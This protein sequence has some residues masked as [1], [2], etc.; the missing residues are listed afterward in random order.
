MSAPTLVDVAKQAD[1]L[2]VSANMIWTLVC[3]FLVMFMQ[4]GFALVE[5][6]LTRSKNVAHTMAM[7]FL[8]YTI[9][10]LGFWAVGFAFQMGGVGAM[11]TFGGDA[12]LSSE[13]VVSIAGHEFGLFGMKGF[14]LTFATYTP[15]V[16]TMFLFQ[17]VFMDTTATIPTGAMAERWKF[18]SFV[19]FSFVISTVIYP[20]Y[21]NWVWGGGWLSTLGKS[22]GLGHGHVDFAGSSVVHMT[23]GVAALVGAKIL[24]PRIGKYNGDGSPN[25]I[26]GHNIPMAL[27][28]TFILA[29]GWFGFNP[30]S[31]L[32]GTDVR[33][34]IIAV[35]TML[36]SASGA[37]AAT[38]F[39]WN[40]YGKPDP[41]WLANGMLAGL[42]AITAPCAF[43]G[44]PAAIFIGAVAGV[45]VV[46]SAV[47]I[48][49][50]LKID[51]PVGASSV[52][53]ACGAWGILSLGLFAN[54]TY[55]EGLNGVEGPVR[56]LLAG[57]AG[58]FLAECVGILVNVVYV[59]IVAA[60]SL[61]I[62]GTVVGNRVSVDDEL[63]GLDVPEMGVAGYTA[64]P[65]HF[66]PEAKGIGRPPASF[67]RSLPGPLR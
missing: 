40:R 45:L 8:V 31:T 26:P 2:V 46:L 27:L 32:A 58:Q 60:V 37:F 67:R 13:F 30:G 49:Q 57:D 15:A 24:G 17:M 1:A 23:G 65:D 34:S 29:F 12:T 52:H 56:G 59:G 50:T 4:A 18:S 63:A 11:S 3:G 38:L 20:I 9:G 28:G 41:T 36:A 14:F 44:A 6:G 55:G 19:L 39:V 10:I 33:I 42:V 7:N 16:A 64:E 53:G 47:F 35:N 61:K 66:I 5:T 22:F 43:V 51:D 25:P 62:I 21:A 48:E 54:G